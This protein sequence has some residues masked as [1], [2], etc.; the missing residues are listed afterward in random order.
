[1]GPCFQMSLELYLRFHNGLLGLKYC[2]EA[3]ACS[4]KKT[5][6][7]VFRL[8]YIM[9]GSFETGIPS[10]IRKCVLYLILYQLCLLGVGWG[11]CCN[12]KKK[13]VY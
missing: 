4:V 13:V 11:E 1:M 2:G 7:M 8:V 9:N 5:N 3:Y 12:K 6:Y 10:C